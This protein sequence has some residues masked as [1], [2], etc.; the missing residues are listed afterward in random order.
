MVISTYQLFNQIIS[1]TFLYGIVKYLSDLP[2]RDYYS[3][4]DCYDFKN[5]NKI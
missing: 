4:I 5:H 3:K 2:I 1:L